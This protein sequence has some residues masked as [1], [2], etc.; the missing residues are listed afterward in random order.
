MPISKFQLGEIERFLRVR[1]WEQSEDDYHIFLKKEGM[2]SVVIDAQ[3]GWCYISHFSETSDD[4]DPISDELHSLAELELELVSVG[5][6][7]WECPNCGETGGE[8]RTR[9]YSDW[10][11]GEYPN[12]QRM[13][14]EQEGCT[15]CLRGRR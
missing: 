4:V 11:G 2:F 15:L 13:E 8:P 10:Q 1:G 12:V 14:C 6:M 9:T 5:A 3:A 7:E